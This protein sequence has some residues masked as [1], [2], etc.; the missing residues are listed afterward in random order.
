MGTNISQSTA[1]QRERRDSRRTDAAAADLEEFLEQGA[2][3]LHRLSSAGT[4]L[5]ANRAEYEPFGYQADEYLGHDLREFHQEPALIDHLLE[6]LAAGEQVRG[7]ESVMRCHDGTRR[8]VLITASGRFDEQGRLLDTRGF[9]QDVTEQKRAELRAAAEREEQLRHEQVAR[10]RLAVLAMASEVLAQSLDYERTLNTVCGLAL[11]L[12]GDFACFELREGDTVRRFSR[13]FE[14]SA[15]DAL[16]GASNLDGFGAGPLG[17]SAL[18]AV[19]AAMHHPIDQA[20]LREAAHGPEHLGLLESLGI[21]SIISVPL[22]H[23]NEAQGTLALFFASSGRQHT[24]QDLALAEELARRAAAA[25]V[26]ARLFT[27]ARDAIGVRDDFL[28][29]AGH[30]LRTPLTALQLQILSI[31]KMVAQPDG[32]AKVA[33]RAE[34]AARNVL[35]LSALV[36]E[37]LD[38]S[39]ISAGRLRLERGAMDMAEAVREVLHRHADELAKNGCEVHFTAAGDVNGN[40]DRVRV[41]QIATNLI[42]NAL[43]YGKGKPIEVR[44]QREGDAA[45]LVVQDH[46]IGISAEDQLRI[47]Q[48]FERAVSSRHFGGLGLGLWIARQ[49]VDAHGGSIEVTSEMN[50]GA[51]FEVL[52]PVAA[53]PAVEGEA[54]A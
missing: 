51:T 43:K 13:A 33:V 9:T 46:G 49:L 41:E 5:W 35:R 39:R 15:T 6:R 19:P 52:L 17:L 22:I 25:V 53:P 14:D 26:N 7:L 45:R 42:T 10:E 34:K 18:S 44:V 4:V 40:W 20:W 50:L 1:D 16:I 2:V 24:E 29:M 30:E 27:E 37:L 38:I 8:H 12:L 54:S 47:F 23:Q 28:S 36:N 32:A 21:S 31:S 3:G 11:P 48:R